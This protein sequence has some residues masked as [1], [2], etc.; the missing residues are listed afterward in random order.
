[1]SAAPVAQS[2]RPEESL[3]KQ[4]Q[5]PAWQ[6]VLTPKSVILTFFSFAVI[7]IPIG[8]VILVASDK[9][10]E[11]DTL[12]YTNCEVI[13]GICTGTLNVPKDMEPPVYVYY[14]LTNFYQNHRRYVKSRNDDQ[15]RGET[16]TSR[17]S[18]ED[19]D[20]LIEN[21][22]K[23]GNQR[24]YNPCG[25]I[26][27][28]FFNDNFTFT[29]KSPLLI[30]ET[31]IAWESDRET[32]FKSPSIYAGSPPRDVPNFKGE[33]FENEHF[34]VWMRT[35]GLPD[36]RKLYGKINTP[37][38]KGNYEVSIETDYDV[39]SFGGS[40]RLVLSTTTWIGGKNDFLAYAYIIV[41]VICAVLGFLFLLKNHFS[42]RQLG[43]PRYL[44]WNRAQ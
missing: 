3:F 37:V 31:G 42:P 41:G 11:S 2:R 43:D 14:E 20:P 23:T 13:N 29:G 39:K 33:D 22:N 18:L 19:C 1:M 15:L 6:P 9:V 12:D 16:V 36:F 34:M 38:K 25:L 26:A 10:V 28:S 4:Q 30:D 35:A 44:A 17:S 24:F 5:L 7:F 27:N 32:K 21:K 8:V 40:K